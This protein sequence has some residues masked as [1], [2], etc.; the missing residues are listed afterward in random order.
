MLNISCKS[1]VK[2]SSHSTIFVG[3]VFGI[4]KGITWISCSTTTAQVVKELTGV[5]TTRIQTLVVSDEK[6]FGFTIALTPVSAS[7]W[8]VW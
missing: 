2:T 1:P 3:F 8:E 7:V 4:G 6:A 5:V